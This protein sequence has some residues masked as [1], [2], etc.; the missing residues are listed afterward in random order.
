MALAAAGPDAILAVGVLRDGIRSMWDYDAF[1][2]T[3]QRPQ[4]KK[5]LEYWR[6][7]APPGRL[8]TRQSIDPLDLPELLPW[9]ILYDVAWEDTTPRFRFRLVGTGNVQ[10]YGRDATGLWFEEAYEGDILASQLAVFTE[11]AASAKPSL[12][13]NRLPI[14][15]REFVEYDRL[16]LPLA[17]DG[18]TVDMLMALMIFDEASL[19][20]RR[21]SRR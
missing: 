6:S 15:G 3:V 10:R 5:L 8:P 7:K 17:S 2:A 16:I 12:M 9:M 13:R 20:P 14:E 21:S 18:Q 11:V 4:H 1:A 19:R